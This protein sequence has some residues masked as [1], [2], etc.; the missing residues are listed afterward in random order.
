[1]L[2]RFTMLPRFYQQKD[3]L[4][5]EKLLKNLQFMKL[6]WNS[7]FHHARMIYKTTMWQKVHFS[8]IKGSTIGITTF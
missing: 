8:A 5:M 1:M 6:Q 7:V 4:I 2:T 3:N